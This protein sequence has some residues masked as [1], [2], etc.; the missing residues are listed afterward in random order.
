MKHT[1]KSGFTLVELAIVIVIIGLIIGGVLVGQDLIKAATVRSAV[2]QLEKYDTAANAFRSKYNGLPG[3]LANPTNFFSAITNSGGN[4]SGD[5]D[6]LVEGI[7]AASTPC[8]AAVCISGESAIF[9]YEL[10]QAGLIPEAIS[11]SNAT[12]V[13]LTVSDLVAPASKIGKG[14][15]VSVNSFSGRNFYVLSNFGTAALTAGTKTGAADFSAGLSPMEAYNIDTKMDDA[16][17]ST[18]KVLSVDPAQPIPNVA[19][20]GAVTASVAAT[21]CY[22]TTNNRYVTTTINSQNNTDLIVCSLGI[23]TSF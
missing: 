13:T 19:A 8:T 12:N 9:W 16:V 23:R 11:T 15:R 7:S 20:N 14:A 17:P 6:G 4:G 10:S 2:S 18:G 3:D 21:T 1:K 5:N 22:E